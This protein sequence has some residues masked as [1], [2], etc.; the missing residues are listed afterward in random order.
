MRGNIPAYDLLSP[1]SLDEALKILSDN[2]GVYRPFAGGTD[3]MVVLESGDL[4]HKNF[5]NVN[6][7][8][9]LRGIRDNRQFV[10]IGACETYS[11]LQMHPLIK[12]MFPSLVQAGA[13]TG[14]LAIQNR[15]TLGG[16]IANASP[17]ADSPPALLVYDAQLKIASHQG[18]RWLSYGQFHTGYKTMNLAPHELITVVRLPKPATETVHFYQKAGT[19]KAQAIS[20][21][22][23]AGTAV[24]SS[25]IVQQI[26]IA[27]GSVA[28]VTRR[29]IKTEA[30]L[31]R[32]KID[33][34]SVKDAV[35]ML[36]SEISPLDD[37]RSTEEFRRAVASNLLVKFLTLLR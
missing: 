15:G 36:Q 20:K 31:E 13:E 4:K 6:R 2:P 5:L 18:E 25:G 12:K 26:R 37:I 17:A 7:L 29:C 33:D 19:R 8:S 28:P 27:V 10:D 16:N 24:V 21:V 3:L 22:V 30:L 23:M 34:N 9:E 11:N 1:K 35:Q 14:G 32:R